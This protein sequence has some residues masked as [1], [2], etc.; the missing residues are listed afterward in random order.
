[1]ETLGRKVIIT[2]RRE[3][4]GRQYIPEEV[5]A[6]DV[7]TGKGC[8]MAAVGD[9]VV[10]VRSVYK[11]SRCLRSALCKQM[12]GKPELSLDSLPE[13]QFSLRPFAHVWKQEAKA[14]TNVSIFR[15]WVSAT[16]APP[17]AVVIGQ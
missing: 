12:A 13:T 3:N 9:S 15:P 4:V 8:A 5:W 1:M 2:S 7:Y 10:C 16:S 6:K 17:P 14:P 11:V